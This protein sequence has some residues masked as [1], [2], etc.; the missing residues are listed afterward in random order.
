MG[1][2]SVIF[3]EET[4]LEYNAENS[5]YN[6]RFIRSQ[7]A[8]WND[9]LF[10]KG[11]VFLS[12]VKRALG[13]KI[14]PSDVIT[15][16]ILDPKNPKSHEPLKINVSKR[17]ETDDELVLDFNTDGVIWNLIDVWEE[18]KQNESLKERR[19]Q[20]VIDYLTKESKKRKKVNE[21]KN[22]ICERFRNLVDI[23]K[24]AL[25]D[26][27]DNV[28]IS[29]ATLYNLYR[30]KLKSPSAST[31]MTVADYFNVSVDYLCGRVDQNEELYKKEVDELVKSSYEKYLHYRHGNIV[32][33]DKP[34]EKPIA[35][36]PYNLLDE[37]NVRQSEPIAYPISENQLAS[38]EDVVEHQLSERESGVIT[39]YF[40]E[41]CTL[42]EIG[43]RYSVGQERIRQIIAKALRKLRH[44]ARFNLIKYGTKIL[45]L[46][47]TLR[48]AEARRAR[49]T[50]EINRINSLNKSLEDRLT[51]LTNG[52][53]VDS[54]AKDTVT[55]SKENCMIDDLEL[56][57]RSYN[58][59]V[60]AFRNKNRNQITSDDIFSLFITCNE[61]ES[62][63]QLSTHNEE[64]PNI[65]KVRNLGKRSASEV[66]KKL[67]SKGY[68]S[69]VLS[70]YVID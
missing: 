13:L 46:N 38:L 16:C 66:A 35:M 53:D 60:R 33:F 5:F 10:I 55:I 1:N 26:L 23:H 19:A 7:E 8:Y 30:G 40:K 4:S 20:V 45:E 31:L 42:K 51:R 41:G 37:I 6:E 70:K 14:T 9:V 57:V 58:C 25:E 61:K 29:L 27:G 22:I 15:G 39:L 65:L 69:E 56:S 64:M 21:T 48:E 63:L 17:D 3:S 59:L 18:N 12:G 36:Y 28:D 49:L 54:S 52:D 34:N 11:Y 67:I 68:D 47:E 32:R 44:P 24:I 50:S 62:G 43:E 2:D